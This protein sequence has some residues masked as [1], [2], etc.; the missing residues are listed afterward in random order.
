MMFARGST[1]MRPHLVVI[2]HQPRD[3]DG[4]PGFANTAGA[5]QGEQAAGRIM[6]ESGNLAE[7]FCPAD[8]GRGIRWKIVCDH[9]RVFSQIAIWFIEL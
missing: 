5:G 7:F 2:H 6:E 3:L 9:E 4:Q 8:E 1:A